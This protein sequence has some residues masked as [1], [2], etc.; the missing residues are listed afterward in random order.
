MLFLLALS[1]HREG[2]WDL[3]V[4]YPRFVAKGAVARAANTFIDQTR[5]FT[6]AK[7]PAKAGE[8]DTVLNRC[9][10][11]VYKALVALLPAPVDHRPPRPQAG[12]GV[13][14]E[15]EGPVHRELGTE[16]QRGVEVGVLR[17]GQPGDALGT[18]QPT[19]QH[20]LQGAATRLLHVHEEGASLDRH[21]HRHDPSGPTN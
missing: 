11:S 1:A 2:W 18:R 10:Q 15:A 16:L 14:D 6:L 9:V 7:A 17:A 20:G 3:D 5:P 13:P 4:A 21:D 12:P 8:L 19:E